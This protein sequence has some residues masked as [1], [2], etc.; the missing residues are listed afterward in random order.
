MREA[1]PTK[2]TNNMAEV[3]PLSKMSM[4]RARKNTASS[5]TEHFPDL[6]DGV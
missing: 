4:V 2:P 3:L 5:S 6:W 1:A